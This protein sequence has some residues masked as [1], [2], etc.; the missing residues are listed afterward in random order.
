[1]S[2]ESAM[3]RIWPIRP[4]HERGRQAAGSHL[5]VEDIGESRMVVDYL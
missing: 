3:E 4:N 2:A 5:L 1:M